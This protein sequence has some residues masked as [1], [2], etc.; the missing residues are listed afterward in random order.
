MLSAF[1]RLYHFQDPRIAV[2]N[3]DLKPKALY[4]GSLVNMLNPG[5]GL[6]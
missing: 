4:E 5:D 1:L 6:I 3:F 2:Q